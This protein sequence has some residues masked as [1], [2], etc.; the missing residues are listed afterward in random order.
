LSHTVCTNSLARVTT[1]G[2]S[3]TV[4]GDGKKQKISGI[5]CASFACPVV[6]MMTYGYNHGESIRNALALA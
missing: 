1:T 5:R 4:N 2:P 6:L 3:S